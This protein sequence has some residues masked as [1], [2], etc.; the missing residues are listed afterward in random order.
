[1]QSLSLVLCISITGGVLFF[2]LKTKT[3]C[4]VN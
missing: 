1:M 3:D 2:Q 4:G